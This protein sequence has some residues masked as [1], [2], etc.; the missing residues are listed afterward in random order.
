MYTSAEHWSIISSSLSVIII[1]IIIFVQLVKTNRSTYDIRHITVCHAGQQWH[2]HCHAGQWQQPGLAQ[3]VG[4]QKQTAPSAA[5]DPIRWAHLEA[6]TRWRH[7][8][9][10]ELISWAL[11]LI[12]RPRKDGRLSWLICSGR[13]T[14]IVVTRRLQDMVISEIAVTLELLSTEGR[15]MYVPSCSSCIISL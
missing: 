1:I 3:R 5:N 13:F 15:I 14:H 4:C 7:Q 10:V 12:Y 8:N 11:L 9:E 2:I 6:F